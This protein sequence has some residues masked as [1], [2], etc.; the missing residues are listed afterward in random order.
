M[1][2]FTNALAKYLRFPKTRARQ[3]RRSPWLRVEVLEDR[4]V[5][6]GNASGV[7]TGF[8]FID[9]NANA[10][11]DASEA[12]LH[13]VTVKLT[14]TTSQGTAVNTT[15]TSNLTGA[16]EFLNVLPGNYQLQAG[17]P[18]GLFNS[19]ASSVSTF[20]VG[21]GQTVHKDLGFGGGLAPNGIW[22][23]LFLT[24]TTPTDLPY[25]SP[26]TGEGTANYRPNNAPTISNQIANVSVV[27]NT[28]TPT[29]IDLAGKFGDP[30]TTNS[31]VSFNI[32]NG[33]VSRTLRVTLFDTT[34]PQTVTNFFNYVKSGAYA[35]SIFS[36]RVSGFVLQGGGAKLTN[37]TGNA[38]GLVD[39]D[40]IEIPNEFG[41]SNLQNTLAMAQS[42]GDPNSATDQF[43][44]NLVNNSGTLDA[45]KF[46]VFGQLTDAG[47]RATLSTL[48]AT[49]TK[50]ASASA[51]AAA[52]PSVDLANVPLTGYT[53][54]TTANTSATFPADAVKSN[55]MVIDSINIS[56]QDEF[57]TYQIVSVTNPS[58]APDLVTATLT[59]EHLSL[60][61]AAGETGTATIVV[62]ATDRY[63]A[64]KQQTFTVK[65][66]QPPSATVSIAPQDPSATALLTA[67]ATTS[68]PE[69]DPVTLTY[70]W[71]INGT[72]VKTTPATDSLTDVLNLDDF[73]PAVGATV[74][75]TATPNDGTTN[76]TPAN[77]GVTVSA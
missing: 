37:A 24:S 61:Y 9:A 58:G 51:A 27:E 28:I 72:T 32:T 39:S 25:D 59:N 14:G 23:G 62:Q 2:L 7:V 74:T 10:A 64:V 11:Y 52:L 36:R 77:S 12:T 60:S 8:T 15:A 21:A 45:Q 49:A 40:P 13:G 54:G 75:V 46:T 31:Q 57:L 65:V 63:G 29:M 1:R 18:T 44:F 30:D 33:G 43:F 19:G 22:M 48:A 55:F 26:G 5:P 69:N 34:A 47:S 6:S 71:K 20:A 70:V 38:L 53:G 73:D 42:A 4:T 3:A 67:T 50:N 56:K 66:D 76:G 41:A 17:T 35:N 16:F 68:D